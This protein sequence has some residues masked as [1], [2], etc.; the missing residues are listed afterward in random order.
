MK[1]K[2]FPQAVV[3]ENVDW[4]TREITNV[5]KRYGPRESGNE[6]CLA[7]QKHIKK[8]MDTFCYET[9]FESYK[10][11]LQDLNDCFE[12]FADEVE[13]KGYEVCLYSSLNFLESVWTNSRDHKV[14]LANYTSQTTY[15]GEYYMWQH[16]S[17]GKIDGIST[18]VDFNVLYE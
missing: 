4:A 18:A 16:S 7:A 5:I 15:S 10:M 11:N 17:T 8:E 9:G 2:D 3:N 12:V 1:F 6:N 14:W 13:A